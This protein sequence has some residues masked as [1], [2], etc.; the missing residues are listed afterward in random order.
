MEALKHMIDVLNNHSAGAIATIGTIIEIAIR[1]IPSEKPM[2]I[3]IAASEI[4]HALA[5][6]SGAI[7]SAIDK[8]IPQKLK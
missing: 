1:L 7:A 6:I 5:D 3:M 8:I 4:I 2:S